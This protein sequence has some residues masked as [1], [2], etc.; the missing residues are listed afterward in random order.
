[1]S[2]AEGGVFDAVLCK[3]L[4]RLSRDME[5]IAGLHKRLAFK[6]IEIITLADGPV[7]KLLMGLR[8]IIASS[9]LDDL[10][11]K[12]RRGQAG[13]VSPDTYLVVVASVTISWLKAPSAGAAP[14][15]A[16]KPRS[17]VGF[18]R[19]TSRDIR[20]SP[21]LRGS[22]LRACPRR[23]ADFGTLQLLTARAGGKTESCR[24]ASTSGF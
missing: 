10:A 24:I 15:M 11:Q 5:D 22:M 4:D 16:S 18:S 3:S 17:Y 14:S 1:M 13:R 6:D 9:F 20:R 21:S 2:A 12:T 23:A 7:S 8:A 19:S